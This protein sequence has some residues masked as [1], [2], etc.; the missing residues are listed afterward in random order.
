[1]SVAALT[2]SRK[3]PVRHKADFQVRSL[4]LLIGVLGASAGFA[5]GIPGA[6]VRRPG[7]RPTVG[8]HRHH[9]GER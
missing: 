1:M 4:L 2:Y 9:A 5:A 6:I 7:L 8:E 3:S